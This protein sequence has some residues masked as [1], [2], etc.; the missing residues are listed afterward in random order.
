MPFMPLSVQCLNSCATNNTFQGKIKVIHSHLECLNK[1]AT[2]QYS[3]FAG[4]CLN[5]S[6]G[7]VTHDALQQEKGNLH[8]G[9]KNFECSNAGLK[10]S[11]C[12]CAKCN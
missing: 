5:D 9:M 7:T 3:V 8:E 2:A 10:S 6:L 1:T 11:G 12:K 4:V